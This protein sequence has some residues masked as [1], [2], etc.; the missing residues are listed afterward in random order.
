M[1]LIEMNE[2]ITIYIYQQNQT[3]WH[4]KYILDHEKK[5]NKKGKKVFF[6][7]R[8]TIKVFCMAPKL[9]LKVI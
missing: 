6:I 4:V 3:E 2:N 9:W 1:R 7:F 5:L 8:K